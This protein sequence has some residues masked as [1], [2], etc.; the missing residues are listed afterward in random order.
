MT[1]ASSTS[2]PQY[3]DRM[4]I[5]HVDPTQL[6]IAVNGILHYELAHRITP[7]ALMYQRGEALSHE[8]VVTN[9]SAW[10]DAHGSHSAG[11]PVS[12][13]WAE[14]PFLLTSPP[15]PEAL[16]WIV[17]ALAYIHQQCSGAY[18]WEYRDLARALPAA[19]AWYARFR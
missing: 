10:S 11:L 15:Q 9:H 3:G 1:P 6:N 4:P 8:I 17:P 5:D 13:S 16:R 2:W 19:Q 12:Y 7:R 18:D 14:D